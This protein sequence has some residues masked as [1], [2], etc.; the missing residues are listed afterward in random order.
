MFGVFQFVHSHCWLFVPHCNL[1]RFYWLSLF[2]DFWISEFFE[3]ETA[4]PLPFPFCDHILF[5]LTY[6]K[7]MFLKNWWSDFKAIFKIGD[8]FSVDISIDWWFRYLIRVYF[9]F[10]DHR[11]ITMTLNAF[12]SSHVPSID[13]MSWRIQWIGIPLDSRFIFISYSRLFFVSFYSLTM[14]WYLWYYNGLQP[15]LV[16]L[17]FQSLIGLKHTLF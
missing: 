12:K 16:I 10:F 4:I 6:S 9:E 8:L 14:W 3:S 13:T 7:L 5:L 1:Q 2:L 17:R 15:L 11:Q